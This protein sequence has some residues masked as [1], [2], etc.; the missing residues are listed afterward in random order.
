VTRTV[1]F[2]ELPGAFDDFIKGRVMGRTVV[3]I[4]SIG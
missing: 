3:K 1:A 2:N 4:N